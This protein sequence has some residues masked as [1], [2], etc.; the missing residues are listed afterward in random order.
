MTDVT[1][2][3][4]E[5]VATADYTVYSYHIV[6]TVDLHT[7]I[8]DTGNAVAVVVDDDI[9]IDSDIVVVVVVVV[10]VAAVIVLLTFLKLYLLYIQ[11]D[12]IFRCK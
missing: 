3:T 7:K 6:E 8:V 12:I 4:A 1:D 5:T 10:V 2:A 11:A 9:D